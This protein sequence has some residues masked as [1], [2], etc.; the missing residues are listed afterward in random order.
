MMNPNLP[1]QPSVSVEN[2]AAHNP[3]GLTV[4]RKSERFDA[5][6][7]HNSLDKPDV[8]NIREKL[9]A[10]GIK[11]WIDRN[12]LSGGDSLPTTLKRALQHSAACVVFIGANG[13]G[14]WQAKE[15]AAADKLK[16]P[17]RRMIPVFLPGTARELPASL[18]EKELLWIEFRDF[19]D[20][21]SLDK[22]I[23]DIRTKVNEQTRWEMTRQILV[24]AGFLIT[25]LAL[26]WTTKEFCTFQAELAPLIS[27]QRQEIV[28]TR[29]FDPRPQVWRFRQGTWVFADERDTATEDRITGGLKLNFGW[30]PDWTELTSQMHATRRGLADIEW[31]TR[32][33][34]DL[35]AFLNDPKTDDV[36]LWGRAEPHLVQQSL[37]AS[38]GTLTPSTRT[39]VS[40]SLA[41]LGKASPMVIDTLLAS[42]NYDFGTH[43]DYKSHAD[44][45]TALINLSTKDTTALTQLLNVQTR[46]S[47]AAIVLRRLIDEGAINNDTLKEL[48]GHP[49]REVMRSAVCIAVHLPTLRKDAEGHLM[50]IAFNANEDEYFRCDAVKFLLEMGNPASALVDVIIS[51]LVSSDYTIQQRS[52]SLLTKMVA[53][54]QDLANTAYKSLDNVD[55]AIH[56]RV[57]VCFVEANKC[58]DKVI[59]I[60]VGC[61]NDSSNLNL[62]VRSARALG[63]SN[64]LSMSII[65][66]LVTIVEDDNSPLEI[67]DAA[68]AALGNLRTENP[69]VIKALQDRVGDMQRQI[70]LNADAVFALVELKKVDAKIIDSLIACLTEAGSD[71]S[72]RASDQLAVLSKSDSSIS[73]RVLELANNPS[74]K[75]RERAARCLDKTGF[76]NPNAIDVVINLLTDSDSD[77]SS[78]ARDIVVRLGRSNESVPGRLVKLLNQPDLQP[79]YR[80]IIIELVGRIGTADSSVVDALVDRMQDDR[81]DVGIASIEALCLLGVVSPKIEAALFHTLEQDKYSITRP[82][83]AV[84]LVKLKCNVPKSI[85]RLTYFLKDPIPANRAG[86]IASLGE[87]GQ[88]QDDWTDDVMIEKLADNDSS[89]RERAGIVLAYRRQK[90]DSELAPD[91]VRYLKDIRN[92]VE[93]LRKD[94]RPWVRQA[95]LHALYHIEKRKAELE[96]ES[97]KLK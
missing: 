60:L 66:S 13:V 62:Q 73:D 38:L 39:R 29:R 47:D 72:E 63:R 12:E 54:H 67:A 69:R 8:E 65:D 37:I 79:H 53:R 93:G 77:V 44:A 84:A 81:L 78:A 10:A 27:N 19:D 86:V 1:P 5:F 96:K 4:P 32:A 48:L 31:S 25:F 3:V 55:R 58:D 74:A 22:L 82:Y 17:K 75:T 61:L 83:I 71:V 85:E 94:T 34:S 95:S 87:L 51:M 16:R 46:Q 35:D 15:I 30:S 56:S 14:P 6:L 36:V 28:I 68:T 33:S 43:T 90:V 76:D 91:E 40:I 2:E 50:T 52:S 42:I 59:G 23:K 41:E 57:A 49:N 88:K 24:A 70:H 92:Q 18:K 7:S 21:L 11:I 20:Q 89:V 97:R 80:H 64:I 9:E 26:A 45:E